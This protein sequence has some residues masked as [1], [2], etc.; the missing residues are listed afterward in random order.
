[1]GGQRTNGN[2]YLVAPGSISYH[3]QQPLTY[4]SNEKLARG[5]VVKI[6]LKRKPCLGIILNPTVKPEFKVQPLEALPGLVLPDAHIHLL[7]WM[8]SYYPGSLGALAQHFVPSIISKLEIAANT[9]QKTKPK[10]K[11]TLPA[12]T[13]EQAKVIS[14]VKNTNSR[15]FFLHGETGS[16]KTRVYLEMAGECRSAG[17]SVLVLTPEISLTAPLVKQFADEFGAE[18]VF[19]IHSNLTPAARKKIWGNLLS[20]TDPAVVIGPRS[21]LFAPLKDLGLI[22]M[23]ECHDQAYKQESAP[24]YHASRVAGKLSEITG[25]KLVMGTGTPPVSEYF[26]AEAK[27]VPVLRMKHQA[28]ASSSADKPPIVVDMTD[29]NQL[30]GHPPLSKALISE[31]E[32]TLKQGSQ[33]LLFLNK[34]GSARAILCQDCG[35]RK[36]CPNCDSSLTYHQDHHILQCHTCGYRQNSPTNCEECGSENILFKSPGT[37]AVQ[38]SLEKLFPGVKIARFDRDNK[39][40]ERIEENYEQVL[41]GEFQI[42]V[43]TQLLTKGHDLPALGLAAVLDADSGLDFPDYTSEERSYQ[44]I[45]QLKGRINRGHRSGQL[46]VQTYRPNSDLLMQAIYSKWSDFYQRQIEHRRKLRFPPFVHALKIEAARA[47]RQGAQS[48]MAKLAKELSGQP[49]IGLIGPSP[50]YME[51]RSGKYHWQLIIISKRRSLLVNI[52]GRVSGS[53]KAELDPLHFL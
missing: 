15:V 3:S 9:A 49:G 41:S 31:L 32:K 26:F 38:L 25:A 1:M 5:Q 40:S 35:W 2:Y 50:C 39:K 29:K 20:R 14:E 27:K 37:K 42:I 7:E 13:K 53:Y 51:R 23:D 24:Y 21:A 8:Q 43:G 11:A 46:L 12:L 16:G 36:M 19:C 10:A 48:A 18:Q 47:N 30:S 44:L 28:I 6:T 17:K 22:V 33:A 34:R 4:G 52:A 45:S